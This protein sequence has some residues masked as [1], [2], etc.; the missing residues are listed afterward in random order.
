MCGKP[1]VSEHGAGV[2]IRAGQLG[3]VLEGLGIDFVQLR[4]L[5]RKQVIMDRRPGQCVSEAEPASRRVD[6]QQ[7]LLYRL[8]QRRM[9]L[10]LGQPSHERQQAVWRPAGGGRYDA[11]HVLGARREELRAGQQDVAEGGREVVRIDAS[12]ARDVQ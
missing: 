5:T 11:E 3:V 6:D 10:G 7:L 9:E 2:Q 8:A 12:V 4:A 1:V